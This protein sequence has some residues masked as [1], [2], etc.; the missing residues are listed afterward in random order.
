MGIS[1]VQANIDTDIKQE[2]EDILQELGISPNIAINTF[3]RQII[4]QHG[5]PYPVELPDE[6]KEKYSLE[7]IDQ[8]EDET[9]AEVLEREDNSTLSTNPDP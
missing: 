4:F 5:I 7:D 9:R 1:I 3:Y 2:A 6:L 8:E